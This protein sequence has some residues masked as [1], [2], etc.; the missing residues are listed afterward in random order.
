MDAFNPDP[1]QSVREITNW[2]FARS[3]LILLGAFYSIEFAGESLG[4][5]GFITQVAIGTAAMWFTYLVLFRGVEA[6]ISGANGDL[7][8][9]STV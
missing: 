6:Y 9:E 8:T 2:V 7:G 3:L 1:T 4:P 5:F